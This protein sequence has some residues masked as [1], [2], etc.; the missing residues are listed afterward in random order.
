MGAYFFNTHA[1][2]AEGMEAPSFRE[3][4]SRSWDREYNQKGPL[5]HGPA[6]LD[7]VIPAGSR[8]LE[9]G[10]GNGKTLSGLLSLGC[11]ITAV[12]SSKRAVELCRELALGRGRKDAEILLA[13]A[14]ALPF[15]D[16]SFEVVLAFHVLE[17]LLSGDRKKAVSEIR[18]VLVP[19]GKALVRVFSTGD[20]RF[21]KGEEVEQCT[22]LRGKNRLA[23]HYFSKGEVE[24]LFGGFKPLGSEISQRKL[25]Y[26]GKPHVRERILASFQKL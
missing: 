15:T 11:R 25:T 3:R 12:D 22:F 20:M 14:C 21:G 5:W 1:Q 13:D 23:Y 18:R 2:T 19:G 16:S 10:C 8:V 26:S 4:Q 24:F 7:A 17:H 6:H 9:L